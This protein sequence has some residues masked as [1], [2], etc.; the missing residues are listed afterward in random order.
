MQMFLS[1]NLL[2]NTRNNNNN[3]L[4]NEIKFALLI[5]QYY[6]SLADALKLIVTFIMPTLMKRHTSLVICLQY[7]VCKN[8]YEGKINNLINRVD[9]CS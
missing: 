1:V 6:I 5:F 2:A 7:E 8:I 9:I 4:S 3:R